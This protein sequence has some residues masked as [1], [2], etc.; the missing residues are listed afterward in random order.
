MAQIELG[1]LFAFIAL[2]LP[3][4]QKPEGRTNFAL[5]C[6]IATGLA[7]G[8]LASVALSSNPA[9]QVYPMLMATHRYIQHLN[10][11]IGLD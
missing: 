10:I 9:S 5:P 11:S 1:R 6:C 8:S 7:L 3:A 4:G 2:G